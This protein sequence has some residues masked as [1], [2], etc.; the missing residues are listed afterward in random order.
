MSKTATVYDPQEERANI[1]TH[2][3][4]AGLCLIGGIYVVGKAGAGGDPLRIWGALVFS[5]CM[6]LLYLSSTLYHSTRNPVRRV[7]MRTLDHVS[8]YLQIAGTYTPFLLWFMEPVWARNSLILMWSIALT[9]SIFKLF[10]TGKFRLVSTVAYIVMGWMILFIGGPIFSGV[11]SG[12]LWWLIAGGAAYTLGAGFYMWRKLRFH[13]AIWHVFT[14]LGS[15][16]HWV[17]VVREV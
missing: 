5:V 10:F 17:A 3:F 4:G 8:I 1:F 2:A 9:G 7:K 14:L 16:C 13:H 6:F 15:A 12:T 11:Q